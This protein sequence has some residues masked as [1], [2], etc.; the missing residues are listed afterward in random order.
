MKVSSS[1]VG[2]YTL[3]GMVVKVIQGDKHKDRRM[4]EILNHCSLISS[5]QKVDDN[6][7][8]ITCTLRVSKHKEKIFKG[9]L[10][11]YKK[12]DF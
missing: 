12:G 1:P 2:K 9:H 3:G 10:M 4:I 5:V 11:A 8:V 6:E 7:W